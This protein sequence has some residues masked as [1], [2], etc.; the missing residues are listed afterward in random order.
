MVSEPVHINR[1]NSMICEPRNGG[2][3]FPRHLTEYVR[4]SPQ[5]QRENGKEELRRAG[6]EATRLWLQG[7]QVYRELVATCRIGLED[8]IDWCW[9]HYGILS[10]NAHTRL[11]LTCAGPFNALLTN[12][13]FNSS[14]RVRLFKMTTTKGYR[15]KWEIAEQGYPYI[16]W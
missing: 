16:S 13:R 3:G 1:L 9:S 15:R 4:H 8:V 12:N 5:G 14:D 10:R 2:E 11:G 6:R 7:T